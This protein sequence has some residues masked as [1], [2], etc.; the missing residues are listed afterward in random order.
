[1]N[2]SQRIAIAFTLG[3]AGCS[4]APNWPEPK[5]KG[6]L[7]AEN[8]EVRKEA[9]KPGKLLVAD[10]FETFKPGEGQN[11]PAKPKSKL[12]I[13]EDEDMHQP[14]NKPLDP[15]TLREGRVYKGMDVQIIY[16]FD[17]KATRGLFDGICAKYG[18]KDVAD[19]EPVVNQ[20]V[21]EIAQFVIAYNIAGPDSVK[22]TSKN[23]SDYVKAN[24]EIQE[25]PYKENR[26]TTLK[27]A[28]SVLVI[29]DQ[30]KRLQDIL[31]TKNLYQKI[32]IINYSKDKLLEKKDVDVLEA[33]K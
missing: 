31:E 10:D 1:M 25:I 28:Q 11:V 30:E 26:E 21:K 3:V 32:G 29:A 13:P 33:M 20:R 19:V 8:G 6:P 27:Y 24:K 22:I 15:K 7:L 14:L 5:G 9:P 2:L 18:P 4:S 17:S 12:L 16:T 23:I